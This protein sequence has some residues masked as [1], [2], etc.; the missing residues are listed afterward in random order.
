MTI[1]RA[2]VTIQ[3]DSGVPAD[4]VTNTFHFNTGGVYLPGD[5]TA[6][7]DRLVSFYDGANSHQSVASY[8]SRVLNPTSTHLK[9][10]DLNDP[11]PRVPKIDED[12]IIGGM[13]AEALPS[14]IAIC[15]SYRTAYASGV[16]RAR[17][18]GRIFIGPVA[19]NCIAFVSGEPTVS[20]ECRDDLT[21]AAARLIDADTPL[22]KW[23]VHSVAGNTAHAP[24]AQVWVD[25]AFDTQRRRG[26][27]ATQRTSLSRP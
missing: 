21:Q 15:L 13:S 18:R 27:R 10:Y 25:N 5:G 24:I 9:V 3:R 11:E 4:A 2:M 12:L 20:S 1:L 23:S 7:R 26:I 22:L 6:V 19:N 8:L 17:Q 14:E 16:A